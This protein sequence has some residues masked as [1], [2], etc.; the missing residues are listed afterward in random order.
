MAHYRPASRHARFFHTPP[1]DV[2][3]CMSEPVVC[4]QIVVGDKAVAVPF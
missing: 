3:V 4:K 1:G 2:T